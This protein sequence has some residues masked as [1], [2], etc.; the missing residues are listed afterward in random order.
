MFGRLKKVFISYRRD[1]SAW[2]ADSLHAKLAAAFGATRVFFD[3]HDIDYGDAFARVI[4]RR[5]ADADAVVAI[6]GPSWLTLAGSD[7]Q[8]RIESP[9]DYVRHEIAS[10]LRRHK[11]L[12]PVCIGGARMPDRASLPADIAALAELNGLS[13]A[14]RGIDEGA[15]HLIDAIRGYRAGAVETD[16]GWRVRGRWL[17]VAVATTLLCAAWVGLFDLTGL[18][19]RSAS[20]TIWLADIVA[21]VPASDE[22]QLVVVDAQTERALQQPFTRNPA[23]RRS[24]AELIRRLSAAGARTI[25]FDIFIT[26]PSPTDDAVLLAA[27]AQARAANTAIVFGAQDIVEGQPVMLPALRDA[28]TGWAVLCYGERL[29]YASTVPLASQK[30][31]PIGAMATQADAVGLALA[32]AYPGPTKIADGTRK[33]IVAG[34]GG[35][36]EFKYSQ[37]ELVTATQ[38]CKPGS[39]GDTVATAL[40]RATPPTALDRPER[41]LAY[42]AVLA[43]PAEALRQRFAGRTVLVGLQLP[44]QDLFATFHGWSRQARHGMALHADA[45]SALLS[46]RIVQP[47]PLPGQFAAMLALGLF[48]SRLCQWRQPGLAWARRAVL[49][50]S[51]AACIGA[52]V[53]LCA[54]DGLLLNLT[55]PLSAL[56]IGYGLTARFAL[57]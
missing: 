30:A 31:P 48:G 19:T 11:K 18:D 26:M 23:A 42:E 25:A 49:L 47:L 2:A 3:V 27:I 56:A 55:Y 13:V 38:R 45:I 12:I 52:A 8:P 50:A 36:R 29:G 9:H 57:A 32:A 6:I 7:G 15:D 33:V 53:V 16:R 22:L 4:D 5:I 54:A 41:R 28:V 1:D 17:A 35:I 20:A 14:D 24:H 43:L 10:A 44:D 21:P 37:T 51:V 46:G 40:Y 39:P 34:A